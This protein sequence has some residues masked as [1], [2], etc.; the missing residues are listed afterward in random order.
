MLRDFYTGA[1]TDGPDGY[2]YLG[3]GR[4]EAGDLRQSP[5]DLENN[6]FTGTLGLH[7]ADF[8]FA[9]G[10]LIDLVARKAKS[11]R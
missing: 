1:C 9:M 5:L 2:R 8:Q 10:D 6:R 4:A 11:V 7:V 3:G